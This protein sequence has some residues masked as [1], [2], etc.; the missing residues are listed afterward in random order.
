MYFYFFAMHELFIMQRMHV[1][2]KLMHNGNIKIRILYLS[3]QNINFLFDREASL[4][5]S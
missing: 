5:R 2:I 3:S 4:T 1:D